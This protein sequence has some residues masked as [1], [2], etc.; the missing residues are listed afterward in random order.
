MAQN[1]ETKRL[2]GPKYLHYHQHWMILRSSAFYKLQATEFS[3]ACFCCPR[4]LP[5]CIPVIASLTKVAI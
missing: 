4:I 5:A 1:V 3:P 2:I